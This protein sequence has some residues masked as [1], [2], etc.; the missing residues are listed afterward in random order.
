VGSNPTL[1]TFFSNKK[2]SEHVS[3]DLSSVPI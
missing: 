2:M 3:R 1:V